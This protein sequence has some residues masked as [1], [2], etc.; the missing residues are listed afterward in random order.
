MGA[1]TKYIKEC[2]YYENSS[3]SLADDTLPDIA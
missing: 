3:A 2:F 1:E